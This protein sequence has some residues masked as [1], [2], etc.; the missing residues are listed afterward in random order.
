MRIAARN[1]GRRKLADD[2]HFPIDANAQQ[3]AQRVQCAG[4]INGIPTRALLEVTPG[5]LHTEGPGVAGQL[6]NQVAQY[7]FNGTLFGGNTGFVSL[8]ELRTNERIDRVWIGLG[9]S[10]FAL[11]TEDGAVH[12]FRCGR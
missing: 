6:S 1:V 8:V 7:L 3:G 11:R 12:E 2:L 5:G 10:G 4:Y 9:Q